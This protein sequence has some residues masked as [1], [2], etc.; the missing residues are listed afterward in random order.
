M[1]LDILCVLSLTGWP[2]SAA[3]YPLGKVNL[4]GVDYHPA[5]DCSL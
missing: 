3:P 4:N 1:G 2:A 5:T